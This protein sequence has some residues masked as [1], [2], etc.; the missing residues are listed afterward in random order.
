MRENNFTKDKEMLEKI[1]LKR[2]ETRRKN[3]MKKLYYKGQ[4][5]LFNE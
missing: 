3:K 1:K 2:N 5:V 4:G